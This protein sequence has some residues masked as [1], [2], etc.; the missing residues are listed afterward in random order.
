MHTMIRGLPMEYENRELIQVL[1]LAEVC[2]ELGPALIFQGGTT[3]RVFLGGTK[4]GRG[5][6]P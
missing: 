1:T 2:R 6:K 3:I 5:Q 4:R